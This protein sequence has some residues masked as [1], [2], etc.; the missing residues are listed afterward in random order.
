MVNGLPY[1][2]DEYSDTI[3]HS[4]WKFRAPNS[5]KTEHVFPEKVQNI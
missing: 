5:G 3:V 4:F 2:G 1:A